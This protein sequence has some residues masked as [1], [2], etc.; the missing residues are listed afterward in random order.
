M[1]KRKEG[2]RCPKENIKERIK[3]IAGSTTD[4]VRESGKI[5]K[6]LAPNEFM[7]KKTR[8]HANGYVYCGITYLERE[9]RINKSTRV[10]SLVA[11]AFCEKPDGATVV[12]HKNNC[13]HDNYYE[14]LYWT[15]VSENT[16]KAFGDGL[17]KNTSGF[18]DSQSMPV[19][20]FKDGKFFETVGSVRLC[21]KKYEVSVSTITRKCKD[22][23]T[24]S[25]RKLKNFDFRFL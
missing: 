5:Y 24:A 25:P 13:K 20:V 2:L 11:K 6:E 22:T 19:M 21:A 9:S 4:Y 10:H 15:T 7:Q 16:K 17:A 1:T 23:G 14:N 8:V 3:L 12:G 18:E